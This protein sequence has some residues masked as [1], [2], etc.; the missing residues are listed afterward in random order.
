MIHVVI[1]GA[2]SGKSRFAESL[3]K[4][5]KKQVVYVATATAGD[6]EMYQR[7]VQ[8]QQDRPKIWQLIEEPLNLADVVRANNSSS[9]VLIIECITLW[10]SNWLCTYDKNLFLQEK[11]DFLDAVSQSQSELVIVSNE[12][13]SGIVPLGEMSR[14]FADQAG[15]MNQSLAEVAHQVTLVVAG[16]PLKLKS[17]STLMND[18]SQNEN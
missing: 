10:L 1:G 3:A 9:Q 15:W 12:V 8:H 17:N 7:I 4:Q 13:G 16:C 14:Q 18:G 6:D 5:S 2:R 11:A